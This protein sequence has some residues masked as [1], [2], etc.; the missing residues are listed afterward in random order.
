MSHIAMTMVPQ[1]TSP[2]L[3]PW[4]STFL[5]SSPEKTIMY[6]S[7]IY[8]LEREKVSQG[9]TCARLQLG[10]AD[11]GGKGLDTIANIQ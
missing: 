10:E 9:F 3:D 8:N 6:L 2:E 11:L 1:K 7:V 4:I 5:S